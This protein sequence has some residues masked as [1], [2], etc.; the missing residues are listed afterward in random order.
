MKAQKA[1][2]F[3]LLHRMRLI[4]RWSLMRNTQNE[5]IQEHSLEVAYLAHALALIRLRCFPEETPC[6]SPERCVMLA[7]YHDAGEIIT[8]DLPTP[9]KYYNAELRGAFRGVEEAAQKILFAGI[10]EEIREDYRPLLFPE[11]N[12]PEEQMAQKIVKAADTLSAYIKCLDERRAANREFA[13]AEREIRQKLESYA[14]PELDLF[15]EQM[16]PS[17]EL[18]LD[19][20]RSLGEDFTGL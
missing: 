16:L 18:T 14:L 9:V 6:P 3:A 1:F 15:I 10:P 7:L 5:N 2:F 19:E 13:D 12:N 8:G 11:Q 17:F 4:R 20:L